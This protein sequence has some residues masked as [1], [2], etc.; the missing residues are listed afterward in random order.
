MRKGN[1]GRNRGKG[2]REA[3]E[4]VR[5]SRRLLGIHGLGGEKG[6]KGQ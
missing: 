4:R 6:E 5:D 3:G 2:S 1:R